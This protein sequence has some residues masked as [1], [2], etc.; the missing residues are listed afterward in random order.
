MTVTALCRGAILDAL[1]AKRNLVA[2]LTSVVNKLGYKVPSQSGRGSYVVNLDGEPFCTCPDFEKHQQPCKHIYAVEFIIQREERPDGVTIA[3]DLSPG[4]A[5]L[6]RVL[7]AFN[8]ATA[9]RRWKRSEN[10]RGN[11]QY[12]YF[13]GAVVELQE[14]THRAK[15]IRKGLIWGTSGSILNRHCILHRIT[16]RRHWHEITPC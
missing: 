1:D 5:R 11:R 8:G 2:A 10:V 9:F 4:L 14:M 6:R 16:F 7:A 3:G 12:L 15:H 13:N